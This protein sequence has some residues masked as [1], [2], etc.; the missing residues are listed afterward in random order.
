MAII[1]IVD[2]KV[3][4]IIGTHPWER[5]NKQELII[6]ISLE[7]D[8]SK[9][10]RSDNLKD[11][12]DYEQITKAVIKT[13]ENSQCHLLEKLAAKVMDKIKGFQG[14]QK[15]SLRIDKPQALAEARSISYIING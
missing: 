14:L 10:S 11:A 15:V 1:D 9:A 8:A 6:N 3:R 7:Y 13:V 12:I 4:T 2:L 5:E